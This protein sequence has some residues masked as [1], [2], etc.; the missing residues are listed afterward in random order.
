M[1]QLKAGSYNHIKRSIKSCLAHGLLGL[2]QHQKVQGDAVYG[3]DLEADS[4]D[5]AHGPS[6]GPVDPLDHDLVVLVDVVEGPVSGEKCGCEASVLDDLDPDA[7]PDG[8][9]GL[10]GLD[11]D[12]LED[13]PPSHWGAFEEALLVGP[14]LEA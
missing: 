3:A 5:V 10:L 8:R 7:L 12:L 6:A 14:A 1:T 2:P 4:R 11:A 13:D 9:V